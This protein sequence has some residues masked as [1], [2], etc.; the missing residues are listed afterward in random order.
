MTK[1]SPAEWYRLRF[2]EATKEI[3]SL[4]PDE[5]IERYIA[6]LGRLESA[7]AEQGDRLKGAIEENP[8]IVVWLDEDE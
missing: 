4:A 2:P 8:N 7:K 6:L 5:L 1:V 3:E